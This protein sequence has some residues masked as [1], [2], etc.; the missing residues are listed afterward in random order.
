MVTDDSLAPGPMPLESPMVLYISRSMFFLV[1][2]LVLVIIV[3]R[4]YAGQL[5]HRGQYKWD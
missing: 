1:A 3:T 5:P 2:G 4:T